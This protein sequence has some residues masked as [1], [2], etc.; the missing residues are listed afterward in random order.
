MEPRTEAL[1]LP[2][3]ATMKPPPRTRKIPNRIREPT[4]AEAEAP[5][6]AGNDACEWPRAEQ[7]Q[8][9][10]AL[11][12][13]RKTAEPHRDVDYSVLEAKLP[14]RSPA[15]IRSAVELL[16]KQVISSAASQLQG[17]TKKEQRAAKPIQE[18]TQLAARVT[19]SHQE[20]MSSAFHQVLMVSSTEPCTLRNSDPPLDCGPVGQPPASAKR[21]GT[22][23]TGSVVG[24]AGV[25]TTPP[26][27]AACSGLASPQRLQHPPST[28]APTPCPSPAPQLLN[29]PPAAAAPPAT[30]HP[31]SSGT[32]WE[33][34]FERIYCFLGAVLKPT[35]SSFRLTPMESAVVLDLLMSLP[36]ELPLLDCKKLHKHFTQVFQCFSA[37][38]DSKKAKQTFRALKEGVSSQAPDPR[39]SAPPLDHHLQPRGAGS[40]SE[41]SLLVPPLNPF[42]VPLKLLQRREQ[43]FRA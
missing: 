32:V 4:E 14:S 5:L 37:R 43:E 20:A 9:L 19:G 2:V 6:S 24:A 38:G 10:A 1:P 39:S 29:M 25:P 41:D 27:A 17:K 34:N 26:A 30:A 36:E 42:L 12:S 7:N 40:Q 35:D 33:V 31:S 28:N 11:K 23:G 22:T 8:L 16:K 18:W 13:L 15:E 3:R 21:P